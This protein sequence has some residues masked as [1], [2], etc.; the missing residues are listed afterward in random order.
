M[1]ITAEKGMQ[2]EFMPGFAED[3]YLIREPM[4]DRVKTKMT[5]EVVM[6]SSQSEGRCY[7]ELHRNFEKRGAKVKCK[8][9][10]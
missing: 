10:S 1:S 7:L 3:S 2:P 6:Y 4:G 5:V 9:L 8:N